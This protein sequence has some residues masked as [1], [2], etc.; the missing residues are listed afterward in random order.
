MG[1]PPDC[2]GSISGSAD[3]GASVPA[4]IWVASAN[5]MKLAIMICLR[6]GIKPQQPRKG[7]F[8]SVPGHNEI[9]AAVPFLRCDRASAVRSWRGG[10]PAEAKRWSG[11]AL[12]EIDNLRPIHPGINIADCTAS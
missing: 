4:A 10:F 8:G 7:Q 5:P 3:P 6:T 9:T 1:T 12:V 11:N 2:A